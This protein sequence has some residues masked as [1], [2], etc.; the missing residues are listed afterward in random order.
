MVSVSRL[1]VKLY[2]Q[3]V[4]A[5]S[6]ETGNWKGPRDGGVLEE[7]WLPPHAGAIT[8]PVRSSEESE[9]RF[10][11]I[12]HIRE[13]NGSFELTEIGSNFVAFEVISEGDHRSLSYERNEE[14]VFLQ[15]LKLIVANKLKSD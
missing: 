1:S 7:I 15:A 14:N 2:Q 5:G 8:A 12:I 4:E 9:T 10:V 6:L 3:T 11:E 13:I